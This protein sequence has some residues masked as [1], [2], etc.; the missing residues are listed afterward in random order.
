MDEVLNLKSVNNE[1][2]FRSSVVI[3]ALFSNKLFTSL[4]FQIQHQSICEKSSLVWGG[5][6][7]SWK[8][9]VLSDDFNLFVLM[10]TILSIPWHIN[11]HM[12]IEINMQ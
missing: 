10:E 9:L 2:Y 7:H 8:M 11:Q 3:L 6:P 12:I 1:N 4:V 5:V